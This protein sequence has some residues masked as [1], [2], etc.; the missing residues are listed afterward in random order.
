MIKVVEK[1]QSERKKAR[2]SVNIL[3]LDRQ[4]LNDG[5]Q[6]SIYT[7]VFIFVSEEGT[8]LLECFVA[9]VTRVHTTFC[10]LNLLPGQTGLRVGHIIQTAQIICRPVKKLALERDSDRQR[11]EF[12]IIVIVI[13]RYGSIYGATII[14][15]AITNE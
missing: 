10:F 1:R 7:C 4:L 12:I 2:S 11:L 6:N 13:T 5:V 15:T 3:E 8:A 14:K 9:K